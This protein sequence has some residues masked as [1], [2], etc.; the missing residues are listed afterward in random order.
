MV[1]DLGFTSGEESL[2]MKDREEK[3]TTSLKHVISIMKTNLMLEKM[4]TLRVS[5]HTDKEKWYSVE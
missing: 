5:M 4:A 2:V 1:K 3:T